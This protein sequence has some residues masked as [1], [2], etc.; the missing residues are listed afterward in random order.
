MKKYFL[1]IPL[2]LLTM[3]CAVVEGL[4]ESLSPQ[5]IQIS[6]LLTLVCVLFFVIWSLKIPAQG[7]KKDR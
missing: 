7:F 2:A 3:T 5:F 6:G 4:V 1:L